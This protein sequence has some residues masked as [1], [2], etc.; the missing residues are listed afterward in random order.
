MPSV[1]TKRENRIQVLSLKSIL[2]GL[3]IRACRSCITFF[4]HIKS[5]MEAHFFY[6]KMQLRNFLWLILAV[7]SDCFISSEYSSSALYTWQTCPNVDFL[8]V[9]ICYSTLKTS[10]TLY[11]EF[12]FERLW[13]DLV[14]DSLP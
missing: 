8:I 10:F 11:I 12:L 5:R 9:E 1:I 6:K 2:L 4:D 13:P 3:L 14:N 7:S